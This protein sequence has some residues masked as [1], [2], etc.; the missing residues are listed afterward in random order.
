MVFSSIVL[1]AGRID[2][3]FFSEKEN[4]DLESVFVFHEFMLLCIWRT[5]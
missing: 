1:F 4:K 5:M 3:F 2:R